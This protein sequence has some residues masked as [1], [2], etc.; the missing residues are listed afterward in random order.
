MCC[1]NNKTLK[2]T[3]RMLSFLSTDDGS[4]ENIKVFF[5]STN[6]ILLRGHFTNYLSQ[7]NTKKSILTNEHSVYNS[8][9]IVELCRL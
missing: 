5:C 4:P 8:A 6:A 7:L 2:F 3:C 1:F 9:Y